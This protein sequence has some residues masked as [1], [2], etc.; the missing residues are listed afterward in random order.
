MRPFR[1]REDRL[2]VEYAD[3]RSLPYP[4]ES[5]DVVFSLSSIEHFGGPGDVAR[6]AREMG[7]V[8]RPG[9]HAFVVTECFVRLHPLETALADSVVRALTLG[10]QARRGRR[11]G[12]G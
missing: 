5:F 1:Y 8:L 6:A 11:R 7:R 12:G 9:G 4:D 3:A 2:T 10:A